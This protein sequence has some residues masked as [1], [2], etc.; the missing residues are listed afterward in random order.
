M[1][2]DQEPFLPAHKHCTRPRPTLSSRRLRRNSQS[3][4]AQQ[5]L[6]LQRM[7]RREPA[8]VHQIVRALRAPVLTLLRI[9]PMLRT[10]DLRIEISRELGPVLGEATDTQVP[11]CIGRREVDIL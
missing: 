6:I 8:P 1:V 3:R 9:E 10:N 4:L 2:R 7:E 5:A 11:A